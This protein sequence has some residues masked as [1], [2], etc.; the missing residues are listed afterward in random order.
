MTS[1]TPQVC[2]VS[3]R[4]TL[5]AATDATHVALDRAVMPP[6]GVW[7]LARYVGFLRGTLAVLRDAEPA[8]AHTLPDFAIPGAA[9]RVA[10][11][12]ADLEALGGR[13]AVAAIPLPVDLSEPAQAFG[14]AYV[15]EGSMLGGQHVVRAVE[16]DLGLDAASQRYLRAPGVPVGPR[17]SAF[18]AALDAFGAAATAEAWSRAQGAARAT[19][20]AFADAFRREGLI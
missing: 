18:V 13:D 15:I 11:L 3:L 1:P 16:R 19:F 4:D 8:I 12:E 10:R 20:D 5:R 14:A 17:W 6:G 9:T 2:T 7:T